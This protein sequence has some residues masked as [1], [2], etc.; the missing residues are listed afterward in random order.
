M[1]YFFFCCT[2]D[3]FLILTAQHV[4]ACCTFASVAL[5][6]VCYS[7]ISLLHCFPSYPCLISYHRCLVLHFKFF[8]TLLSCPGLVLT[9]N[10][11]PCHHS[12]LFAAYETYSRGHPGH[13]PSKCL[14]FTF[15]STIYPFTFLFIEILT[16]QLFLHNASSKPPPICS[17]WTTANAS[18]SHKSV[19]KEKKNAWQLGNLTGVYLVG[20]IDHPLPFAPSKDS[21]M[22]CYGLKGV[23]EFAHT[24]NY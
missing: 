11:H 9:Y 19:H 16:C 15:C 8:I 23:L 1:H 14:P 6:C 22:L 5:W 18:K 3:A 4:V 21:S 20:Q 24:G 7:Y 2:D 10:T 13:P 17:F 12:L